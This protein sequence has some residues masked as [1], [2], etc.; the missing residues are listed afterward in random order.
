[1]GKVEMLKPHTQKQRTAASTPATTTILPEAS[2]HLLENQGK[3]SPV[4]QKPLQLLPQHPGI[5]TLG[6]NTE[7]SF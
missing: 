4:S 2:R 1:M 5:R 6:F 3:V 7:E